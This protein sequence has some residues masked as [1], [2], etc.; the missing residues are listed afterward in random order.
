MVRSGHGHVAAKPR[1]GGAANKRRGEGK[2]S[3]DEE[4]GR[5]R[6]GK[7]KRGADGGSNGAGP[8]GVKH[9]ESGGEELDEQNEEGRDNSTAR[10]TQ[11]AVAE[12]S[13][14]AVKKRPGSYLDQILA[15][16]ASKKKKKKRKK[17]SE[18]E[19]KTE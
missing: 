13:E 5:A 9:V 19:S 17:K 4:E 8:V 14:K 11:P 15:D 1:P 10:A 16:R 6:L 18:E 7:R 12:A 2:E 3:E